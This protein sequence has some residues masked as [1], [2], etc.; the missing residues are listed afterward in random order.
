MTQNKQN[1]N[2]NQKKNPGENMSRVHKAKP[3]LT[4][5]T[6]PEILVRK[7]HRKRR[8]RILSNK[9]N[10]PQCGCTRSPIPD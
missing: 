10:H 8:D 7:F 9:P 2:N 3:I 4:N 5:Q 6:V 1:N